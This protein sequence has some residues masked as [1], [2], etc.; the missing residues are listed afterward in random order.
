MTDTHN[1]I[2]ATAE[3]MAQNYVD[4]KLTEHARVA[5]ENGI[6]G[7]SADAIT[8]TI[9]I[10]TER[11]HGTEVVDNALVKTI[12]DYCIQTGTS[13]DEEKSVLHV[14]ADMLF[15]NRTMMIGDNAA[16]TKRYLADY[17]A[18]NATIRENIS[19]EFSHNPE[20]FN[21][22]LRD[23]FYA[24]LW[25]DVRGI[26]EYINNTNA[27]GLVTA[28]QKAVQRIISERKIDMEIRDITGYRP[29]DIEMQRYGDDAL[30]QCWIAPEQQDNHNT[31]GMQLAAEVRLLAHAFEDSDN[32]D[33]DDEVTGVLDSLFISQG[34]SLRECIAYADDRTFPRSL[35]REVS[36]MT[37]QITQIA[38]ITVC[39]FIS[40]AD[41]DATMR[42]TTDALIIPTYIDDFTAAPVGI[43]DP[44]TGSGSLFEIE[45][46]RDWIVPLTPGILSSSFGGVHTDEDGISGTYGYS[47]EHVYGDMGQ[48]AQIHTAKLP[49]N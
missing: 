26:D 45:L 39:A 33:D 10:P 37:G 22:Y 29:L 47:P 46:E 28:F 8:P 3:A 14:L 42:G 27:F 13:L 4:Y 30:V 48:L 41:L 31:E 43:F 40:V 11:L 34:Y 15:S 35:K 36:E 44:V 16:A 1:D 20:N 19:L 38:F 18:L 5:V 24:M 7:A 25:H 23:G 49:V 21:D 6:N 2:A 12:N 9:I 17:E 32:L